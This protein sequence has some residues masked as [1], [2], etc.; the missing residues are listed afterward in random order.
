MR[1]SS[2]RRRGRN[3]QKIEVPRPADGKRATSRSVS[4]ITRPPVLLLPLTDVARCEVISPTANRSP[5]R[6]RVTTAITNGLRFAVSGL[7]PAEDD[8]LSL[9]GTVSG[10]RFADGE[11]SQV[12]RPVRPSPTVSG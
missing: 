11:F 2:A 8:T 9:Y 10:L 6:G 3:S 12:G 1:C 7:R 5:N 4:S